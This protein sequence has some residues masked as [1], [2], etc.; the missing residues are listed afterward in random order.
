MFLDGV[1]AFQVAAEDLPKSPILSVTDEIRSSLNLMEDFGGLKLICAHD[2]RLFNPW[3]IYLALSTV[4]Q[5]GS[6][7]RLPHSRLAER[8]S[9]PACSLQTRRGS[10]RW[11]TLIPF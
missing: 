9:A 1:C 3:S 4:V 2:M 6:Y 10:P 11:C 5:G 8:A 7:R